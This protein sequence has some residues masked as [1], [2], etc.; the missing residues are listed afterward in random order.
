MF[1]TTRRRLGI[2]FW[3]F[4]MA[5]GAILISGLITQRIFADLLLSA[6]VIAIG[7]HGLLE[8]FTHRENRKVLSRMEGSLQQLTE[9]I[10]KS[11]LF[12]K[13]TKEK[14]ELRLYHLDA[15][16][17]QAEQRLEKR[18]RELSRKIVDLENRVNSIRKTISGEKYKPLST[19]EKRVAKAIKILRKEG[20]MTQAHYSKKAGVSAGIA[21]NDLRKMVEMKIAKRK[22]TGRNAYYILAV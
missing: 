1:R 15:R 14:H 5:A 22:G 7:F 18:S 21:R 20:M 4:Y 2:A 10:E 19:F 12:A 13:S 11:H 8:E 6:V 17:A 9:W 16:R 3:L